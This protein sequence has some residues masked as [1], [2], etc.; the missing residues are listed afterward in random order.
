MR[1]NIIISCLVLFPCCSFAFSQEQQAN[2]QIRELAPDGAWT[3][4][5]DERTLV[6]SQRLIIGS[7]DS[8]G[9]SRVDLYDMQTG[10]Q[11]AYPLS[12][13]KSK[14]D[15]NNPALLKMSNGEI[16]AC[17][18]QHNRQKQ[19]N[20]RI[21][22]CDGLKLKWGPEQTFKVPAGTTYCNVIQLASENDRIYNFS[23]NVNFN[24]NV[25]YSDDMAKTWQ[26]PF[27]LLK[28]G[29]GGTRPYLKYADNGKDRIDFLY[30]DGHPRNEP[31]NNVYHMYYK[32]GNFYKSDGTLIKT[33]EQVKKDPM[34]PTDGTLI[35]D[36]ST[37]GR[38]WVWDIEYDKE[39]NPVG[40]FINSVDHAEGNDLRYRYATWNP[41]TKKWVQQQ[42]A[43]AG[44]HLYVPENHYAGGFSIDPDNADT[45]Y[46]SAD[47]NPATGK[48]NA[49]GRYQVF[50]GKSP[51]HGNNWNWK[52]LTF[53]TAVDNLRPIVPRGHNRKICV[54]WFQ[55]QYRTY[56]D[57]NTKVVGIIEK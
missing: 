47:V 56:T 57:F 50:Q 7:L 25:Q 9:I 36:G 46:I 41:K 4:Y 29:K 54:I 22:E 30:T 10:T 1:N 52:Q 28:A 19:W 16:L 27:L 33:I 42:I 23:R 53:D 45:V 18:A 24:P 5:N 44:T 17:Y 20:W 49:S 14:D 43:H 6:D 55:G 37:E 3:W 13:W 11:T 35:Y 40:A 2:Y 34:V 12:S 39:G 51:D 31:T 32:K 15:H 48:A 21:A 38:G 26:G 8:Q